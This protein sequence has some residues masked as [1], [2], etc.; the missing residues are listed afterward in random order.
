MGVAC[1]RRWHIQASDSEDA[2][3]SRLLSFSELQTPDDWHG[4][5]NYG[6]VGRDIDGGIGEPHG[7]LVDAM[8]LLFGP[9]GLHWHAGEDA[10]KDCP[11]GVAN[12]DS[13]ETPAC[14]LEFARREHSVVLEKD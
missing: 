9:E 4:K 8:S 2:D 3:Q 10:A 11:D 5:E 7:E 14:E 6:E 12:D 1:E 13:E